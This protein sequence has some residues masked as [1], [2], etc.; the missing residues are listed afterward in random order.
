MTL[1]VAV[2]CT[3][4]VV[5]ASDSATADPESGTKQPSRKVWQVGELPVLCGGSG[6]VGLLQKIEESLT[7][8]V[9]SAHS[10]KRLRQ[11]IKRTVVS[12]LKQN[13]EL[14]VPFP[15]P[16]FNVPPDA[17]T[18]FAF[19][20][21]GRS[22][23]LEIEKHGGD[24]LYDDRLGNFAA[25]GSGKPWA[26]AVFRPHLREA[27]TVEEGKVLA[28]RVVD[29]AIELAAAG[30]AAPIHMYTLSLDGTVHQIGEPDVTR[31]RHF[32]GLWRKLERE[33]FQ[34]ALAP[35]QEEPSA[36]IPPAIEQPHQDT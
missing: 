27:R 29:D 20:A 12:E 25:I 4:G 2:G 22:W 13:A 15:Q 33:C 16:G 17:T 26:Q 11:D 31:I 21:E 8:G 19:V 36:E 24:T 5:V 7:T 32:C 35:A 14:F 28:Y 9:L 6:D 30:L 3:D 18:L 1:V 23:I 34:Q 10:A